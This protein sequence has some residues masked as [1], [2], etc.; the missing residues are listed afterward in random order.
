MKKNIFVLFLMS[1]ALFACDDESAYIPKPRAYHRIDLPPHEYQKF[2]VDFPYTFEYSKYA[3]IIPDTSFM[4]EYYWI[5]IV[6]PSMVATIHLSFKNIDLSQKKFEEYINDSYTLASKHNIKAYAID[7]IIPNKQKPKY[8]VAFYELE[9][10]VPSSFQYIITDST[11]NFFRASLYV[12]TSLKNDSLA[13]VI[14]YVRED[15]KHILNTFAWKD[16]KNLKR[17]KVHK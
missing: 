12:P 11:K 6:Y 3:K 8:G 5:E 2:D 14:A 9:G 4:A 10:D 13:P 17:G 1:F 7:E 15:M 16:I